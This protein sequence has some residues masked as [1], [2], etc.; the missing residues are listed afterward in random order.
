MSQFFFTWLNFITIIKLI[1]HIQHRM[2]FELKMIAKDSS[3]EHLVVQCGSHQ[4]VD[5]MKVIL[6]SPFFFFVS[7]RDRNEQIN[8]DLTYAVQL[9]LA[10][11]YHAMEMY[12]LALS[13]YSTIVRNKQY[14]QSGR[15]RVNMGNIYYEQ[16]K[17]PA[18]IKMY[19]MALDQVP[20][21]GKEIRFKIMRNIGNAFVKLGQFADA[22]QSYETI[23]EGLPDFRT[24]FNLV[25]CYFAL[26][27]KDKMKRSFEKLVSIR[28]FGGDEE[29]EEMD[30]GH[31]EFL[32]DEAL[33]R[34]IRARQRMANRF[35]LNAAKLI[36]PVIEKDYASGVDY[37]I[38]CLQSTAFQ[39]VV[40]ELEISK[41]SNFLRQKKFDKA[42]EQLKL[43]EKRDQ[44]LA[45]I[46]ST[47]LSFLYYLEGDFKNSERYADLSLEND[48]YNAKA[49]VNKGNVLYQRVEYDKA[50]EY[51]IE[52]VKAEADCVE[53]IF[54]LGL[55]QKKLGRFTDALDRF[56]KL[57]VLLPANPEVLFQLADTHEKSGNLKAAFNYFNQLITVL[58]SDPG[59]LA[60]LA[61]LYVKEDD[62]S[63]AYHYNMD[64]FKLYPVNMEVIQ[65][66]GA[67]FVKNEVYEKAIHYFEQ[68][69]LVQPSDPR[70]RL[71]VASCY[72][73]MGSYQ[74]ALETYQQI[75]EKFP[76]NIEC[77]KYLM[78]ICNDLGM[79]DD[80]HE[81]MSRLK[82]AERNLEAKAQ[83]EAQRKS[84]R[85]TRK[86]KETNEAPQ[87]I[88]DEQNFMS[89]STREME[90][91]EQPVVQAEPINVSLNVEG[92][93]AEQRMKATAKIKQSVDEDEFASADLGDDLLPGM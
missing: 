65:W 1:R 12:D 79:K 67:Y 41:A 19:R 61:N 52:A 93:M 60:R 78:A 28:A 43:F 48:S 38:D 17:Y 82:K 86:K 75:H 80:V 29:E 34:E 27:D 72:R 47:N 58:P 54:N 20:N 24:G 68:A 13:T 30:P 44:S 21:T 31:E 83:S 53:A 23:M 33:K 3:Y 51:Y 73:R 6:S 9:N 32:H 63:Q 76:E 92:P 50:R 64:A 69:A 37:V 55:V 40:N 81:Y 26:G 2:Y 25:V 57:Q 88:F 39:S 87:D 10:C 15:L 8:P 49:L 70:W 84:D 35:V 91:Q 22:V 5:E 59:V 89:R 4:C 11:Q 7:C 62:E 90:V 16:K 56:E 42:I 71:M 74:Q 77:L 36:S 14:A 46:A 18:A 66:L 85:K 45:T